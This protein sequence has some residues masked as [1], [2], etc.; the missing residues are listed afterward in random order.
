[1]KNMLY[2]VMNCKMRMAFLGVLLAILS[3]PALSRTK[4][5]ATVVKVKQTKIYIQPQQGFETYIAAA[6]TKKHV[7][8]V[9]VLDPKDAN[10]VLSSTPVKVKTESTG[11]KI[12]RCLFVY[13]IGMEGVQ[14]VSVQLVD[15]K[16]KGLVWAY[17]VHKAAHSYQSSAE[18]IAK[19]LKKFLEEH[20]R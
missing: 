20:K 17:T 16:T 3:V 4:P 8:A 11:S 14:T 9:V 13:C 7:P 12:T 18:A 2:G 1:M 10:F 5:N 19:H 15:P 6:F